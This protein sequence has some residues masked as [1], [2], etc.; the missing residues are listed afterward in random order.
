VGKTALAVHW[1]HRVASEFPAADPTPT[2]D[3]LIAE[4]VPAA[5]G[6]E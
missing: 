4:M 5:T 1:A 6:Y 3:D 2:Q